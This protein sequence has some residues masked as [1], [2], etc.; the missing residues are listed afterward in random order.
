MKIRNNCMKAL[1]NNLFVKIR[2]NEE[3]L[4]GLIVFEKNYSYDVAEVISVGDEVKDVSENDVV[5]I[6]RDSYR[7]IY[8]EAENTVFVSDKALLGKI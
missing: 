7:V 1:K 3:N 6:S 2:K 4:S 5:I 8:D